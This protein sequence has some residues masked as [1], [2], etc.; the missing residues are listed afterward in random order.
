LLG[1]GGI[2]DVAAKQGQVNSMRSKYFSAALLALCG[3]AFAPSAHAQTP[4]MVQDLNP[5]TGGVSFPTGAAGDRIIFVVIDGAGGRGLW[6]TE[7]TADSTQLIGPGVALDFQTSVE[8]GDALVGSLVH[9]PDGLWRTDGSAAGTQRISSIPAGGFIAPFYLHQG[10]AFGGLGAY[11]GAYTAPPSALRPF[12]TDG[13]VEG[14]SPV[15]FPVGV[16]NAHFSDDHAISIDAFRGGFAFVSDEARLNSGVWLYDP[17]MRR[18]IQ[19]HATGT[20]PYFSLRTVDERLFI[21]CG[22]LCVTDGTASGTRLVANLPGPILFWDAMHPLDGVVYFQVS[23]QGGP[24]IWRSD[25]TEAGTVPLSSIAPSLD[26]TTFFGTAAVS[27]SVLYFAA[28]SPETGLELWRTDGTAGGT[29]LL[30]DI[31]PGPASGVPSNCDPVCATLSFVAVPGG[32]IFWAADPATGAE[33]WRT[34]GTSAGTVALPE[35]VPGPGSPAGG[36]LFPAGRRVYF[37]ADDGV[38]GPELWA[39]ELEAGAVAVDDAGAVTE[40]DDTNGTVTFTVRLESAAPQTVLVSYTTVAGTA[41][42]GSDFV[43]RSG[44]LTFAPGAREAF[45]EVSV[46]SDESSERAESFGLAVTTTSGAPVADGRGIVVVLD[47]DGPRVDV[48]GASVIE[49]DSGTVDASFAVTVTTGD[50]QPTTSPVTVRAAAAFGTASTADF[51]PPPSFPPPPLPSVTFPAGSSS[52]TT[53]ALLVPVLGDTLEEPNETFSLVLDAGNDA[54]LPDV[55]PTGVILDDDG[56]AANAP[57]EIAH[58]SRI[59]ADLAPP[60]GRASDVDFYVLRHELHSSYEIVVDGVSGD[61]MPIQVERIVADGGVYQAALPTG[62]GNSVA[63]RFPGLG[64]STEHVRVRSAACGTTCGADDTY[65]LRMYETTLSAPR[66]NTTGTQ[67]TAIVLQN[68]TDRAVQAIAAFWNGSGSLAGLEP[69]LVPAQ[70]VTVRDVGPLIFQFAGSLT[71][72]HDA[73]YGTLVGKVVSLDPATGLALET[74][75]TGRPR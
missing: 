12:I 69:I 29:F 49:G 19:L 44:T 39:L 33:L 48:A 6:S 51:P 37:R 57:V 1:V 40:G 4:Y 31:N 34:D 46:V 60:I 56:V 42:A 59:V 52:G 26:G 23:E 63:M 43:P 38:H 22:G 70:G 32:L 14:T 41:H 47:D 20:G 30:K 13:T 11:Y 55:A 5:G 16:T 8:L 54:V 28:R 9:E 27:G 15:P 62:T 71:I 65:R 66:V 24:R 64:V 10:A 25:G 61:A 53:L 74:P 45:V 3:A 36:L 17:Q 72:G 75:L 68:T 18:T 58:G 21:N 35:I 50:G 2:H 67:S 7:G 73:P